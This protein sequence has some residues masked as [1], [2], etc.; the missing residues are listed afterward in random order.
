M[1]NELSF[2]NKKLQAEL[3]AQQSTQKVT[4]ADQNATIKQLNLE[5]TV[6]IPLLYSLHLC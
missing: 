2:T 1:I 5:I 6:R 4:V 3:Q